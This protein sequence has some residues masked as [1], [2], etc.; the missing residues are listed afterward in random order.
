MLSVILQVILGIGFVMFGLMKFGSKQMVEGF[1]QYGYPSWFRI[2]TGLVEVVSAGLLVAGIW[3]E[4][5]AAWGGLLV[6]VT[7][8]GAVFT[9]IKIKDSF[10]SI[11]MPLVLL[12]IGAVVLYLQW[13]HL[14]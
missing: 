10:K 4:A 7:M 9:H 12:I 1:K 2:F 11:V 8:I 3:K 6:V 14:F 5:L 13:N